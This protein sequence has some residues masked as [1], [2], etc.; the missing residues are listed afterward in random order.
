MGLDYKGYIGIAEKKV[1]ATE[2]ERLVE[3]TKTRRG[4]NIGYRCFVHM[5]RH[6]RKPPGRS[7]ESLVN[8]PSG[9]CPA[10]HVNGTGGLLMEGKH[11]T[12][13]YIGR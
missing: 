8:K 6:D 13:R 11:N 2:Q 3:T 12:S 7:V 10:E 5:A 9:N 1:E 4:I